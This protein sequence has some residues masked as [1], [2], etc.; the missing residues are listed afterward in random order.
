MRIK[1]FTELL[2]YICSFKFSL[3]LIKNINVII[4]LSKS[5]FVSLFYVFQ[6]FQNFIPFDLVIE[7]TKRYTSIGFSF[8]SRLQLALPTY[9]VPL[10]VSLT[11]ISFLQTFCHDSAIPRNS[12]SGLPT[13]FISFLLTSYSYILSILC[14]SSQ[15]SS[16]SFIS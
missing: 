14:S 4:S 5:L 8:F 7:I 2:L 3:I 12:S 11:L 13:S 16:P 15:T 1:I 9:L 10:F 6:L